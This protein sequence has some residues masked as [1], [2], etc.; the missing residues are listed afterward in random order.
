MGENSGI[1]WTTHTF[2][3]W[4]GCQRVSPGCVNCYAEAY[5]KRVGGLPKNQRK[6]PAVAELRWGPKAPRVRTSLANWKKPIAW[7]AAAELA[8][9]RH[10]VFCASL[11][12]VF[13]EHGSIEPRWRL[14]LFSLIRQTP[15]LDWLLLTKRPEA[16]TRVLESVLALSACSRSGDDRRGYVSSDDAFVETR[17]WVS[18]WLS[19]KAPANVWLGTTV[20]DQQRANERIP[21]LVKVP[22]VVRFLS[23]EPLLEP[24]YLGAHV[25]PGDLHWMIIGGESGG[26][27]RPFHLEWARSLVRQARDVR[28]APFVKQMGARPVFAPGDL[29]VSRWRLLSENVVDAKHTRFLDPAGGEMAD[30]PEDIR[31]REFPR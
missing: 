18:M 29:S 2:N 31:V 16:I 9:E 13:E 17:L 27:A 1:Q 8:G 24:V 12:D 26:N 21:E 28:A 15:Q 30:W 4:V 22:A 5:D 20:E 23:I 6:D 25:W 14:E 3:P 7:N 11:S 10:R 19:G